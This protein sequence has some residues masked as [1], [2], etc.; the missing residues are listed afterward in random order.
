M[1]LPK[2]HP[3]RKE[4][5]AK[6]RSD[7]DYNVRKRA[8]RRIAA[9]EKQQ[10]TNKREAQAAQ[11]YIQQL[12]G[13]IERSYAKVTKRVE[14]RAHVIQSLGKLTVANVKGN[15]ARSNELFKRELNAASSGNIST[16]GKHGQS[17]AK[18]FYRATQNFWEGKPTEKRNEAIMKGMGVDSLREAFKRVMRENKTA[19]RNARKAQ[20]GIDIT[21]ENAFFYEE[22]LFPDDLSSPEYLDFVAVMK[23]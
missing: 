5:R 22:E 4:P 18:V 14:E 6:R 7:E 9:L 15:T 12:K 2:K 11:S 20:E 13:L 16:L 3:E 17:M 19:L 8:K 1:P 21:D 23:R 10:F